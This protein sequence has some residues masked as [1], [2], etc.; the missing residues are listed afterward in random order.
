M[1]GLWGLKSHTTY[2]KYLY[3]AKAKNQY[4]E[5]KKWLIRKDIVGPETQSINNY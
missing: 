5:L 4:G 2:I 1:E 3:R